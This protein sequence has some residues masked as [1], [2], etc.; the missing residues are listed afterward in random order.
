[1]S[2]LA[3]S[4]CAT[5]LLL[6]CTGA[7]WAA[8]D[9]ALDPSFDGDGKQ[10]IAFNI[11]GD[12]D[13]VLVNDDQLTAMVLAPGGRIYLAG[14]LRRNGSSA[15]GLTRLRYD[16]KIDLAFG[17]QGRVVADLVDGQ[18][19]VL[20]ATLQQDGK[21]LVSGWVKAAG[22]LYSSALVCRFLQSG[23]LDTGFGD[24][25][26][27]GCRVFADPS[28]NRFFWGMLVQPDGRIVLAGHHTSIGLLLMRLAPDGSDDD[29]FGTG[30][31]VLLDSQFIDSGFFS[32][33][34]MADGDLVA[35]GYTRLNPFD[36]EDVLLFRLDEQGV[37]DESFGP[38]GAK[39]I[40]INAGT[41]PERRLDAAARVHVTGD[42]F[43]YA[44][45]LV[46]SDNN[47]DLDPSL[48]HTL[49]ALKLG[50]NG[51]F[52]ASFGGGVV[53][54]D[55]CII[56]CNSESWDSL[57]LPDGRLVLAGFH[58]DVTS[59]A[60]EFFAMRLLAG[61][62]P[63]PSFGEYSPGVAS[64]DFAQVEAA[65]SDDRAERIALDGARVL[66]AGTA[67]VP[68]IYP[69][70]PPGTDFAITRLD[71][72]VDESFIVTPEF[73][74]NANGTLSPSLS[75]EVP[76][77][78]HIEFTVFPA[79]GYRLDTITGC[80]GALY[81]NV[82]TTGAI[83]ADCSITASFVLKPAAMFSDGFES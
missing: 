48:S 6:L 16:G 38:G 20:D 49:L 33:A 36:E 50:Q 35:G 51:E 63:D 26:I 67:T 45:G 2:L 18:N 53:L 74:P 17:T 43:V 1:M 22:E 60:S 31:T 72:G 81:G 47:P 54:H 5:A 62:D 69:N 15:I 83:V 76:H 28:N 10:I 56:P 52:D 32:V 41:G 25:Q 8:P 71:H 14:I 21:L 57:L 44:T 27:P 80:D 30:G 11:G 68:S 37:P 39:V 55:P 59:N 4:R 40:T 73:V 3:L 64:I 78:D 65:E 19:N 9:G 66:L 23:K 24:A 7:A 42:G 46:S 34:R 13:G 12:A 77:S 79:P 58:R 61:G 82:Y 70:Q 29:T 75:Q